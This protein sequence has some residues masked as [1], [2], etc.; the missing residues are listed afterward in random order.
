MRKTYLHVTKFKIREIA[1]EIERL[2]EPIKIGAAAARERL[3]RVEFGILVFAV[4]LT[5]IGAF[6]ER[7]GLVFECI[8]IGNEWRNAPRGDHGMANKW[9]HEIGPQYA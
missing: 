7:N 3:P 8:A 4:A 5:L 6:R 2:L 1:I 9:W